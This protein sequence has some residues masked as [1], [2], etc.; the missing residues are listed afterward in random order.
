MLIEHLNMKSRCEIEMLVYKDR[1]G[2]LT[3]LARDGGTEPDLLLAGRH[4]SSR[5]GSG[6]HSLTYQGEVESSKNAQ[7]WSSVSTSQPL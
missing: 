1:E 6:S 2:S 5:D 4:H 3:A 7:L